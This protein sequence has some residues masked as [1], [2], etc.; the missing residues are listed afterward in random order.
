[1]LATAEHIRTP[2][3][4]RSTLATLRLR[5]KPAHRSCGFV[6]GAWWPHSTR[7]AA[8]LPSLL[9]ALSLRFDVIDRV[10]Y[11]QNDWSPT[12]PSLKHESGEVILESS[13]DSPNVI[14]VFGPQFGRLALLLVPPYMDAT[15]ACT[16]MTTASTVG[17]ASTPDQLL[18]ISEYGAKNGHRTGIALQRSGSDGRALGWSCRG[19]RL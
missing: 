18:G 2:R 3:V 16:A 11:H 4:Q 6:Q 13:Q 12:P 7:L 19:P 15:D 9:D 14:T 5:L 1:M 10:R 8:E 17:D